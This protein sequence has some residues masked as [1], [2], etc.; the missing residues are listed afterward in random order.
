MKREN[1][2]YEMYLA[3]IY[4]WGMIVLICACICADL[5][6]TTMKIVG[7]YPTVSWGALICFD[8][9]DAIFAVV[10]FF[11]V[12]SSIKDGVVSEKKQ[13]QGKIF[14][15]FVLLIQ[16]NFILYMIPS[17]NFWGLLSFFIILICFFLDLKLICIFGGGLILSLFVAWFIKGESLLPNKDELF[18][19]DQ[20]V[21]TIAL[22]L[23]LMGIVIFV[24]F[25]TH[26]QWLR[27]QDE[28]QRK[29]QSKYYHELL[30]KDEGM[31]RFRHDVK[32]HF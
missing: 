8:F 11:I 25:M 6:Y 1:K 28:Q 9:M 16:W 17:R 22:F 12:K 23:I 4:K 14:A 7:L 19:A 26:M 2:V 20:I 30:E 27:K 31:R 3:S 32:K 5:V 18:L 29:A 13:K 10:A 15:F 24:Y 21:C